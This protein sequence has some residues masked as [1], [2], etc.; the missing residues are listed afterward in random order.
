MAAYLNQNYQ[1]SENGCAPNGYPQNAQ[2]PQT[3][4]AP[5]AQPVYAQNPQPPV[6]SA[7][8]PRQ[9]VNPTQQIPPEYRPLSPWAYF[10]YTLLFS[11]PV[12]GFVFLIVFSCSRANLNRRN[13]ARSYWCMLLLVAI[14]FSFFLLLGLLNPDL[15][16]EITYNLR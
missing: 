9:S 13:F 5:Q 7:Y 12:V 15:W 2:A 14:I 10:G 11:I 3:A 16:N 8:A 1:N 6:Q 4:Y